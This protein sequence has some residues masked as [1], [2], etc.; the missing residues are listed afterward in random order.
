MVVGAVASSFNTISKPNKT[1]HTAKPS[2]PSKT[3]GK[4]SINVWV[5]RPRS[6]PPQIHPP[7]EAVPAV[8]S[9]PI[10]RP[11]DDLKLT[12]HPEQ[13]DRFIA[14]AQPISRGAR[15]RALLQDAVNIS[16]SQRLAARDAANQ[17]EREEDQDRRDRENKQ[18]EEEL[19]FAAECQSYAIRPT[20]IIR[21]S[22]FYC[23]YLRLSE[24]RPRLRLL[25]A[26]LCFFGL[27]HSVENTFTWA[28]DFLILWY[29]YTLLVLCTID[30]LWR[31]YTIEDVWLDD[32]TRLDFTG[33]AGGVHLSHMARPEPPQMDIKELIDIYE[34]SPVYSGNNQVGRFKTKYLY[35]YTSWECIG[36]CRIYAKQSLRGPHHNSSRMYEASQTVSL[37]KITTDYGN[38]LVLACNDRVSQALIT[39]A[40]KTEEE[41]VKSIKSQERVNAYYNLPMGAAQALNNVTVAQLEFRAAEIRRRAINLESD[42]VDF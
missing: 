13:K 6:P 29:C 36:T 33:L 21:I 26:Y 8:S 14:T 2:D 10:L 41:F 18:R 37:V 39:N 35:S 22:L 40:Y 23:F 19:E 42:S 24:T 16:H 28:R 5:V 32:T 1:K 11:G 12:E 38:Y 17:K 27:C 20:T 4:K 25:L 30:W 34:S 31:A 3:R 9:S 7:V 15:R